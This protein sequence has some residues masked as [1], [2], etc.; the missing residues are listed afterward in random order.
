MSSISSSFL[1]RDSAI[2]PWPMKPRLRVVFILWLL[3]PITDGLE[4]TRIFEIVHLSSPL[5]STFLLFINLPE[6]MFFTNKFYSPTT[7]LPEVLSYILGFAMYDLP[8]SSCR[9]FLEKPEE[10]FSHNR[11]VG[12]AVNCSGNGHLRPFWLSPHE[13]SKNVDTSILKKWIFRKGW[14]LHWDLH[15]RASQ[16]LSERL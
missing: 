1:A 11:S 8:E 5:P 10:L 16:D 4:T 13:C 7:D 9:V 14:H 15:F 2:K 12:N 3:E 6:N